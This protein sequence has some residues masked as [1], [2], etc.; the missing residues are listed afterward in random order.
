MKKFVS[1][2]TFILLM[3]ALSGYTQDKTPADQVDEEDK[4]V[5]EDLELSDTAFF[6]KYVEKFASKSTEFLYKTYITVDDPEIKVYILFKAIDKGLN[7]PFVFKIFNA[8]LA[9]SIKNLSY[10]DRMRDQADN[11]KVRATAAYLISTKPTM[12]DNK[13]LA[14]IKTL[15]LILREDPEER[16]QGIAAM[17][18]GKLFAEGGQGASDGKDGGKYR[19]YNLLRKNTIVNIINTKLD[20]THLNDQYLCWALVKT[21]GYLKSESSFFVLIRTR[22]RGFNEKVKLEISHSMRAITGSSK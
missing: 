16:C 5:M 18:L 19:R 2:L 11:W 10:Q 12:E 15:L 17:T 9:E 4:A 14:L 8:G 13:K 21:V 3:G 7:D 6:K 1:I 22:K 20:K